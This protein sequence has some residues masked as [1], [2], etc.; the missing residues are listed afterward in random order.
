MFNKKFLYSSLASIAVAAVAASLLTVAGAI[1]VPQVNKATASGK[2]A[3]VCGVAYDQAAYKEL[4]SVLQKQAVALEKIGMGATKADVCAEVVKVANAKLDSKVDYVQYSNIAHNAQAVTSAAI[5]YRVSS[6]GA[7]LNK[8]TMKAAGEAF[9]VPGK[10]LANWKAGSVGQA[11]IKKEGKAF[12][13]STLAQ[14][15]RGDIDSSSLKDP[16]FASYVYNLNL[17]P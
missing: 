9:E 14:A 5:L 3:T 16:A 8:S 11:A 1:D 12:I 17:S 6:L 2:L 15:N 4:H 7:T 10:M 13:S